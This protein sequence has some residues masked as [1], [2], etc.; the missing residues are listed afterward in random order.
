MSKYVKNL[1]VDDLRGRWKEVNDLVLVSVIGLDAN[2]NATVRKQLREKDIEIL[3]VKNSLAKRA[4]EGTP[5]APAFEGLEGSHAAVW[6]G[7]DIVSVAKEVARIAKQKEYEAFEAKGG[8]MDGAPMSAE[9]VEVV[10]KWPNRAEQLS[11][12]VGQILGPGSNL[13]AQIKGPGGKLA[14]QVKQKGEGD[15]E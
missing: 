11:L 15:A 9:Q 1:I 10:S 6:G 7:E 14:S 3:V 2:Q 12:L 8:V 13:S 4:A 5:L